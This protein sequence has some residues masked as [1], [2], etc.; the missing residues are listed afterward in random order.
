MAPAKSTAT[1]RAIPDSIGY[2]VGDDGSVW[3]CLQRV[4]AGGHGRGVSYQPCGDWVR[5]NPEVTDGGYLDVQIRG[6]HRLVHRLVLEMFVGPCPA[7][8]E[9]A[10]NNGDPSDNRL[11]NLR[12]ATPA[13]NQSD[14]VEHGTD[15]R[16]EKHGQHKLTEKDITDIIRLTDSGASRVVIGRQFGIHPTTV[17]RIA[18]GLAWKHINPRSEQRSYA[19]SASNQKTTSDA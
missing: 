16:G 9:A 3:S 17:R 10:H 13:S 14:R 15:S 4:Y 12:W 5:M 19:A 7:G 11:D 2:R 6:E 8:M 1:Y 18:K